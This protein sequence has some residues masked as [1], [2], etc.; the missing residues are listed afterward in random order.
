MSIFDLSIGENRIKARNSS[1]QSE[2][3]NLSPHH[4]QFIRANKWMSISDRAIVSE[5]TLEIAPAKASYPNHLNPQPWPD[6]TDSDGLSNPP[7]D[8][9]PDGQRRHWLGQFF[10]EDRSVSDQT[11][12][13]APSKES[14]PTTESSTSEMA[15]W[16]GRRSLDG[17]SWLELMLE[18]MNWTETNKFRAYKPLAPVC[19]M[20]LHGGSCQNGQFWPKTPDF[21]RFTYLHINCDRADCFVCGIQNRRSI[22][23]K[24]FLSKFKTKANFT[25]VDLLQLEIFS[26]ASKHSDSIPEKVFSISWLFQTFTIKIYYFF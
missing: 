24:L 6:L 11:L 19:S 21:G 23:I 8:P 18:A 4:P 1:S 17:W 2:L 26:K 25:K 10:M 7:W 5:Q 13:I 20:R 9:R 16:L 15:T 14:Y 12:V 22:D 3:P